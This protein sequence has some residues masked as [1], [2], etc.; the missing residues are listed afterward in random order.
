MD[1]LCD[2]LDSLEDADYAKWLSEFRRI[3][4]LYLQ[5]GFSLAEV[6][7]GMWALNN[8][9]LWQTLQNVGGGHLIHKDLTNTRRL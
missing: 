2:Y 8:P 7:R 6:L 1:L 5:K 4:A 3:T 9:T